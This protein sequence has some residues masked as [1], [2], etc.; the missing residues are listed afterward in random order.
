[1][2]FWQGFLFKVNAFACRSFSL[3]EQSRMLLISPCF[4][5]LHSQVNLAAIFSAIPV[6]TFTYSVWTGAA[7]SSLAPSHSRHKLEPTQVQAVFV[8]QSMDEQ[9]PGLPWLAKDLRHPE[10]TAASL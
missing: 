2:T 1:M 5:K 10:H 6:L 4:W 8:R 9:L 3:I 7:A